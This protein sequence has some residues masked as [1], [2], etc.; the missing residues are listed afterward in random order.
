MC[1]G[2]HLCGQGVRRSVDYNKLL[3]IF[4]NSDLFGKL[5]AIT[6]MTHKLPYRNFMNT[7]L[8]CKYNF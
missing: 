4:L 5:V 7:E 2:E 6:R 3:F 1:M 8:Y